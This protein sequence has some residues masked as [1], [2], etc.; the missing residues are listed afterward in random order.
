MLMKERRHWLL[1]VLYF[2]RRKGLTPAQ[3]QKTTFL[4]QKAFPKLGNL[5]YN[6][7]PY[8]YGPFDV[9]VYQ[10]AEDLA[11]LGL[12]KIRSKDGHSWSTYHISLAGKLQVQTFTPKIKNEVGAYISRLVPWVQSLSFQ[13]LI[14]SIYQKY[15]EYKVNSIFRD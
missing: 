8:N 10:E 9:R 7:Q 1:V 13:S 14:S 11:K 15:P 4:L 12:V 6:F 2:A 5:S 3:L